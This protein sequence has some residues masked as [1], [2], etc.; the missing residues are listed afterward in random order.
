[1]ATGTDSVERGHQLLAQLS[2]AI[3]QAQKEYWGKGPTRAKSYLLDDFLLI[4]MRGGFLPVERTMLEAGKEDIVRQYRQDFENEMSSRLI[5]KMEEL[6]GR[7]IVTY[8]SQILFDPNIVI[9]IFFFDQPATEEQAQATVESQ[10]FDASIGE[11]SKDL[12]D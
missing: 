6:T 11:A 4:V 3:V 10:L 5:A 1:M 7:S 9:E 12:T 2:S 8:Q